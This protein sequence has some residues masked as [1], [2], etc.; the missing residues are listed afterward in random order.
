MKEIIEIPLSLVICLL[1]LGGGLIS[2]SE[3]VSEIKSAFPESLWTSPRSDV[4]TIIINNITVNTTWTKDKSPYYIINRICIKNLSVLKIEPGV[5]VI[6]YPR[7]GLFGDGSKTLITNGTEQERIVFFSLSNFTDHH[8]PAL[9]GSSRFKSRYCDFYNMPIFYGMGASDNKFYRCNFY[10]CDGI[11]IDEDHDLDGMYAV[12]Q[13]NAIRECNFINSSNPLRIL[14]NG[15][16]NR[17][18]L[19]NFINCTF[20]EPLKWGKGGIWNDSTRHGNYWSDYNGTDLNNDGIGDTNLLWHDVDNFPLMEPSPAIDYYNQSWGEKNLTPQHDMDWDGLPDSWEEVYNL[21][22]TN[23][24]D[25]T[26]DNDNDGLTNLREYVEGTDPSNPDTDEDGLYDNDEVSR[27]H[28]NP[29]LNDTDG[30]N[31]T[32]YEEIMNYHTNPLLI[33]TDMDGLS[34]YEEIFIRST[35]P[36]ES[37]SD[38]DSLTDRE[39]VMVY[40]TN[41]LLNDTDG[42]GIL[43]GLEINWGLDPL[44][45][46]DAHA[47]NDGDGVN[48][49]NDAFPFDP[50]ASV[51]TDQDGWPDSWNQGMN[52]N[53]ST[54]GLKID[55]FPSD[56]T[57][58]S[59]SD[60]DG[61]G[62]NVHGNEPDFFPSNPDEWNDTDMDGIGDNSDLDIDGD[63]WNNTIE[64]ITGTSQYN[65][66]SFPSDLDGDDIPDVMDNDIDGDCIPNDFD[67]F[68]NDHCEWND[69]DMDGIGDNS[70]FDIDGDGWNNTI[71]KMIGTDIYDDRSFPSDMDF[72]GI[73]DS[74]DSDRDGDNVPNED[75]DY[76]NNPDKWIAKRA[77]LSSRWW[78]VIGIIIVLFIFGVLISIS[79]KRE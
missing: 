19:N 70:D 7:S 2:Q 30:D 49:D 14:T 60:G 59:D 13:N 66:Q 18:Y 57:Q 42:D 45:P 26:I 56:P 11:F 47:D 1:L 25:A 77:G 46:V 54:T 5:T 4:R 64:E 33:D 24:S 44:N 29:L 21:D 27:F 62:D 73:P 23:S 15:E 61:F 31:L 69:T 76:P 36:L 16:L 41:P 53:N 51:D 58:W 52:E 6:F 3:S 10:N 78:W 48:N 9:H 22:P 72:D 63:G 20:T 32:D 37:D 43:D 12:S 79:H 28:T 74:L 67:V 17:A 68:P 38:S 55:K 50:A 71:E 35:N 40:R 75:D 65:S 34:D 8:F 39:E